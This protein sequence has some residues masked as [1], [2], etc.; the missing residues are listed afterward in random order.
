MRK[1]A[2]TALVAASLVSSTGCF[3]YV[4]VANPMEKPSGGP[5]FRVWHSYLLWG[6]VDLSGKQALSPCPTGLAKFKTAQNGW[7]L[8]VTGLTGGIYGARMDKYWC[9]D[10][11]AP[12]RPAAPPETI[13]APVAPPPEGTALSEPVLDPMILDESGTR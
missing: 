10:T 1:V 5:D 8:L 6:L 2:L 12:P 11:V 13:P 9:N 4:A 3:R 7:N